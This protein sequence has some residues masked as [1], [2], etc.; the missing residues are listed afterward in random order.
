MKNQ[1]TLHLKIL[2]LLF[3]ASFL[4][5]RAAHAQDEP[6]ANGDFRSAGS[7]NWND[8][9]TW[10]VYN[11]GTTSWSAAS[12][13][14]GIN[15][16]VFIE[17]LHEVTLTQNENVNNLH[18]DTDN[19]AST[20]RITT[21][22]NEL[23][24]YG[25]LRFYEGPAPGPLYDGS[26]RINSS[27]DCGW[28][29]TDG[30]WLVFRGS[31]DRTLINQYEVNANG[32]NGGVRV[33]VELDEGVTGTIGDR[34]RFGRLEVASGRLLFTE[35]ADARISETASSACDPPGPTPQNGDLI[36][37]S[38]ATFQGGR[39]IFKNGGNACDSIY[40]EEGGQM[41]FTYN[42]V[43]IAAVNFIIDG[44]FGLIGADQ[45]MPVTGGRTGAVDP[46]TFGTLLLSG[47]GL[48]TLNFNTTI[49]DTLQYAELT[50]INDNGF[51][52]SYGNNATLFFNRG[53]NITTS[54]LVWPATDGPTNLSVDNINGINLHADRT[55]EG[56]LTL[57]G[58]NIFLGTSTLTMGAASPEVDGAPN[59]GRMVIMNGTG[60][61][62]KI[63]DAA[64]SF[65]FPIGEVTGI[66]HFSPAT[67]TLNS[68]TFS[69]TTYM[70]VTVTNTKHPD[71]TSPN[72]FLDRFWTIS[73]DGALGAIEYDLSLIYNNGD[74]T[75]T[76]TNFNYYI[77]SG[78][79]GTPLGYPDV[80]NKA[81]NITGLTEVGDFTAS[82]IC[83]IQNNLITA[84]S[85]TVFSALEQPFTITGSVP[86]T[87]GSTLYQWEM[88]DGSGWVEIAGEVSQDYTS[89]G[90]TSAGTMQFR[91]RV[92]SDV[93]VGFT[94]KYS[95][96]VSITVT[97]EPLFN[98]DYRSAGSGNWNDASTWEVYNES[99]AS[100]SA[101]STTPGINDNVFIEALH[102]VALTQNESVNNL[103]LN[104]DN[105]SGTRR[106][107][108]SVNEL[109]IYGKLRF[110]EGNAPGP[111]YDFFSRMNTSGD[112]GWLNTDGGWLVF[113]GSTDRVLMNQFEV[114]AN[115]TNGGV[116]VRIE[117]DANVT[118]TIEDRF[119][120]G[121]LEVASGRLLFA[122][123]ADA[124]ISETAS[125]ACDPPGDTPQNGDLIVR[126]GATFQGGR[127]IFKNSG[128]ACN[129]ILV[130]EGGQMLFTYENVQ[131]AA[132]TFTINGTFGLIGTA[133]QAMPVTGGRTGATDPNT[134]ANLLLSGA[135][136][137]NLSYTT[138][139]N[140]TL[141][142]TDAA[143]ITSGGFAVSY[144]ANGTLY[145][146]RNDNNTTTNTE[147]PETNGPANLRASNTNGLNM[148]AS[149]TLTGTL[150]L[151]E[152]NLFLRN[153]TLTM[154]AA[155]PAVSGT[156]GVGRMVVINGAGTM[157]KIFNAAGSY[158]FPI[159]E[160]T[161]TE[162][163]SPATITLNSGTF[164]S[165]TYMGVTVINRK[166][167]N[168]NSP[169]DFLRR[170]W[171]IE[172]DDALGT[173]EYNAALIY[174]DADINGS[175][176]NLI[177]YRFSGGSGT[178]L[179]TPDV[180]NND[181]NLTGLDATGNFTGSN[182]NNIQNNRIV[183]PNQEVM[184]NTIEAVATTVCDNGLAA[185]LTING[186]M[187]TGGSGTYTYTWLVSTNGTTFDTLTNL[188][189]ETILLP[190]DAGFGTYSVFRTVTDGDGSS[191]S[192]TVQV[193]YVERPVIASSD[194]TPAENNNAV[195]AIDLSITGGAAPYTFAWSTGS[196]TEDLAGLAAGQY[197]V[198]VTDANGCTAEGNFT[199]EI[200][201]V[202]GLIDLESA[203]TFKLWPNPVQG[204]LNIEV[205]F[206]KPISG[207][208]YVVNVMG[209]MVYQE[210]L[211]NAVQ[212][213]HTLDMS[214]MAPGVYF[215][216]V[217]SQGQAARK[218]II[219]Q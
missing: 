22:S 144:G 125:A 35:N 208:V 78:G 219:R 51:N 50:V 63:F 71:D 24:I 70:E 217:E 159:G 44:T 21:G 136:K 97:P 84:P 39:G 25:K 182:P 69:S 175:E 127:G 192:N 189:T 207:R 98:G 82:N 81:L 40:V 141:Q 100:W 216:V 26:I 188:N 105:S 57:N 77:Y 38:G 176:A 131:I 41:L 118:G 93:C 52:I 55:L 48:K 117:L 170:Y 23:S 8:V 120:F 166:H 178:M 37:R 195:G 150:T 204:N 113:R 106:I 203:A 215:L 212:Y 76:A 218:R 205:V 107:T 143:L 162:E 72:D 155:S 173:I 73:A 46:S 49:N 198:V 167:P 191:V 168:D 75:G 140:D 185:F 164:S 95:N 94:P 32:T 139:V 172:A 103:H 153:N 161:N 181:L 196:G 83:D 184:N 18:L 85:T 59:V 174:N 34:F 202:T 29:N 74:V 145:Y 3:T 58:G 210:L 109:S 7:G 54:D 147:W 9:S 119:R 129:S 36:V 66:Q 146:N 104:T 171:T 177:Q 86:V 47:S 115:G 180:A 102:E 12:T 13:T 65:T 154:G 111:V 137:K 28:L 165:T 68:G 33:R 6:L 61:M 96:E 90:L 99:T 43:N 45:T 187:P 156:L 124:R 213:K 80:A 62:R 201:T 60:T 89:A 11:E 214:G 20:R 142:I 211:N 132:V 200:N 163:Y 126:S 209:T 10:E 194:I 121:R 151:E 19:T 116:R 2:F 53:A 101:A 130:E 79:T 5:L 134:F 112:C 128:N 138:T 114:N 27:G 199:V 92:N 169:T 88:N 135:G 1:Y 148:H 67:I 110:Y 42:G 123:N 16:N 56:G 64:G 179:G 158:T 17:A 152:G 183:G 14:P 160:V 197:S 91:R 15:D 30:G 4:A 133:N 190:L 206:N 186:S 193:N 87:G 122:D 149:R 157:R 108:T 31:S